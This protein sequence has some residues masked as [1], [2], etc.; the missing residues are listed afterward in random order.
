MT[1]VLIELDAGGDPCLLDDRRGFC[2]IENLTCREVG[3]PNRRE[4]VTM[5][6]PNGEQAELQLIH[7]A[8][9]F[10]VTVTIEG[11]NGV[12][13]SGPVEWTIYDQV[14]I[15]APPATV[16][17][18]S[19]ELSDCAVD[20]ECRNGSLTSVILRLLLNNNLQTQTGATVRLSGFPSAARGNEMELQ[21]EEQLCVNVTRV[22][23]WVQLCREKE[24]VIDVERLTFRCNFG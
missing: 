21:Q 19:V 13:V 10:E 8:I 23:D 17:A 4:I 7:V 9:T 1:Y 2:T 18:C 14:I 11:T 3:D 24:I 20:L 5:Q 15:C 16:I 6:L 22:L 12:C